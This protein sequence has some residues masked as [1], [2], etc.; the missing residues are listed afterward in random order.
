[1]C[2]AVLLRRPGDP[3]PLILAANR[4]ELAGRPA[5]PPARH[6]P[7]RPDVVA[8]LD[9]LAGGTWLGLNDAGVVA[10]VLNRPGTLG[11]EA[12]KRSRGELVLDALDHA[13]AIAAAEALAELDGGAFRGFHL[14][15]ADDRD[16]Y[17]LS[18]DGGADGRGIV[19]VQP[20]PA[21]LSLVSAAGPNVAGDPRTERYLPRFRVAPAPDPGA[22][23]WAA[24]QALMAATE[25]D[26]GAPPSA[27]MT[28]RQDGDDGTVSSSLIALPATDRPDPPPPVWHYADGPPDR[29]AYRPVDLAAG[30]PSGPPADRPA[31]P[32][33]PR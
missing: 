18:G 32:G 21:G 6:W 16:A 13:D 9:R 1:M 10:A 25:T 12:G 30:G 33:P 29:A 3:W 8:G 19:A 28:F 23:D 7:D 14:I 5:D 11:P 17:L 26:P 4:D 31:E 22:G 20:L 27:A 2:T 15:V 24:W